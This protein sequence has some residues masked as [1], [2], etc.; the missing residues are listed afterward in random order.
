M[1]QF[2][3]ACLFYDMVHDC[4]KHDEICSQIDATPQT[5]GTLLRKSQRKYLPRLFQWKIGVS[6]ARRS[7][8]R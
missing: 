8:L 2:Y 6:S 1:I 7:F 5:K 3:V 4:L